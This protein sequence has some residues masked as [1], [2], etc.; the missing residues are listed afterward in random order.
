MYL[1]Q[2]ELLGFKSFAQKTKL[3][4][5]DGIACV[6]GPN[7]S[8]KSNIVDSIR[9]VLG[10]QKVT[11][12]RTDKMESVIFNGSKNR[13]PLSLA[14]VSLTIHNNR[15]VLASEYTDVVISRRLYRDGESQYFINQSPCRL[16]DINSLFMDTGMGSN[17]Y[18]VIELGMVESIISENASERRHLFEEAAGVTKYKNH[19]KSALRKLES[20]Q[21]D[22]SRIEDIITEITRNVNSLS[23]QV[24]KARRYLKFQE[25]LKYAELELARFRFAIY[26]DAVTPL[27]TAL[28]EI[29]L[30]KEDATQQIT[31]EEAILEEYKRELIQSEHQ[32]NH[33]GKILH[34]LDE[35]LHQIKEEKA[36]ALTRTAS[37]GDSIRRNVDDISG[38]NTKIKLFSEQQVTN[39]ESLS[40]ATEEFM[41]LNKEYLEKEKESLAFQDMLKDKKSGLDT[42]NTDYKIQLN[43]VHTQKE[44]TQQKKYQHAWNQEQIQIF[45]SEK[46]ALLDS[47]RQ[48][49]ENLTKILAHQEKLRL[50]QDD[51]SQKV[52]RLEAERATGKKNADGLDERIN[53]LINQRESLESQLAFY[54]EII[55]SYQGHS[56]STRT[57][58]K[59][60]EQFP[61]IHGPISDV[62]SIDEDFALALEVALGDA[63][64]YLIVD[65]VT[66]AQRILRQVEENK[67]GRVTI[68]PLERVNKLKI[69]S[70]SLTDKKTLADLMTC[71][72]E[73][74]NIFQLLVGDAV[75][76]DSLDQAIAVS[77]K[78]PGLRYVT[79]S[80]EIV[81]NVQAIT[82]GQKK[83]IK[84]ALIGRKEQIEKIKKSIRR[85]EED[86]DQCGDE[87][88]TALELITALSKEIDQHL[89]KVT[90]LNENQIKLGRDETE[91]RV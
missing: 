90:G 17:S 88:D 46:E 30:I 85:L 11:S 14:E 24:G 13:K 91:I 9:W 72:P 31:L 19:R 75:V 27:R 56:E 79:K 53:K 40:N 22:M 8:G 25:E 74:K 57:L 82:G 36:I 48:L 12:L 66:G 78:N 7:G 58:M 3:K 28:E 71:K 86:I 59:N 87:K 55:T 61:E 43:K 67:L 44:A 29:S 2:L 33:Y 45:K 49:N 6:I 37:L 41:Q 69:N 16:K 62:V 63:I 21:Q 38:Y 70:G 81:T 42:L 52:S 23:R 65:D 34:D 77:E 51:F 26:N 15:N 60:R 39:R 50:D 4:F 54:E 83:D 76:V 32:I 64:N 47:Q 35:R 1:S 68:I 84:S 89:E 10:E 18:S 73:Y 80:G 20:T 5:N